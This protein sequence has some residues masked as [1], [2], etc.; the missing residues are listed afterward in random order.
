[1]YRVYLI[2]LAST[3]KKLVNTS[4]ILW[5]MCVLKHDSWFLFQEKL[6]WY[7]INLNNTIQSYHLFWK[8]RYN[9]SVINLIKISVMMRKSGKNLY[10][11][12]CINMSLF[13]FIK[14]QFLV[15]IHNDIHYLNILPT[16]FELRVDGTTI[17]PISRGATQSRWF[18]INSIALS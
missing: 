9:N 1:M 4:S 10:L 5:I 11:I 12:S 15:K 6:P 16:L 13:I 8:Y 7:R 17:I 18:G 3:F 2:V 14:Q